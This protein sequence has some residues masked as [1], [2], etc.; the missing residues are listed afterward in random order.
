MVKTLKSFFFTPETSR[1]S[2]SR[3]LRGG[4]STDSQSSSSRGPRWMIHG[5]ISLSPPLLP[6]LFHSTTSLT[7]HPLDTGRVTI[8]YFRP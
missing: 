4:E 6:L 8:K 2:E 7:G 1:L 3:K 5:K